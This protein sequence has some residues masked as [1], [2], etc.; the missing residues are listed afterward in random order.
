VTV[1][2]PLLLCENLLR[3]CIHKFA[4]SRGSLGINAWGDLSYVDAI[5]ESNNIT[6]ADSEASKLFVVG[7]SSLNAITDEICQLLDAKA[8]LVNIGIHSAEIEVGLRQLSNRLGWECLYDV[9]LGSEHR[10]RIGD[11]LVPSVKFG[12]G[13]QV[14]RNPRLFL[15]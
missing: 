4:L 3:G 6:E 10:L 15:S 9:R 8:H 1:S 12:D 14:W 7:V 2:K 5:L 11:K 13:V